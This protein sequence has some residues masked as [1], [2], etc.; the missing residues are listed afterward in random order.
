MQKSK[1]NL[2]VWMQF[3]HMWE[4]PLPKTETPVSLTA[5]LETLW[6]IQMQETCWKTE[7]QIS[8]TLHQE[9]KQ[10]K[11]FTKAHFRYWESVTHLK[12]MPHIQ[13]LHLHEI[14]NWKILK[15]ILRSMD[16]HIK[17]RELRSINFPYS[18]QFT[19]LL[20]NPT[21]SKRNK[22]H[23]WTEPSTTIRFFFLTQ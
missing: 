17:S 12:K 20:S 3:C 16:A 23:E 18:K 7:L 8:K 5:G 6:E 1:P 21:Y 14:F 19:V 13:H 22:C 9:M 15:C 2:S 4:P 11:E 10:V